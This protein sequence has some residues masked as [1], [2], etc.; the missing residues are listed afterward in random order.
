MAAANTTTIIYGD[1]A[2]MLASTALVLGMTIP[3]LALYYSG[4]VRV[5]NVLACIMQIFSIVCL[6]SILWLFFGYSLA[7]APAAQN[8]DKKCCLLFGDSSRFWMNGMT[9]TSVHQLAQNIPGKSA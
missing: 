3:G 2:W 5:K 7:F 8:L 9:I 4:L 1:V 6:I